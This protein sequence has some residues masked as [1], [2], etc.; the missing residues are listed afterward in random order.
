MSSRK[1]EN[2][3]RAVAEINELIP[4]SVSG[5]V[6][7]V[8]NREDQKKLIQFTIDKYKSL[9]IL[10]SNAGISPDHREQILDHDEETWDKIMNVNLKSAFILTKEALPHLQKQK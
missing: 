8:A 5:T 7:D 3:R 9:D 4:E 6:C 2:V 1:E 10:V